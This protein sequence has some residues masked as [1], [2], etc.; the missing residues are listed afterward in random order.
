MRLVGVRDGI[1]AWFAVLVYEAS[2]WT[3]KGSPAASIITSH[4]YPN[5]AP[6]KWG[7]FQFGVKWFIGLSIQSDLL[8]AMVK[9]NFAAV[10]ATMLSR[11]YTLFK[12]P[13]H[14][15]VTNIS[16]KRMSARIVLVKLTPAQDRL[17]IQ[18]NSLEINQ[19][20]L[21]LCIGYNICR[22]PDLKLW[23]E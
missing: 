18:C 17:P 12:D 4:Q 14:G 13:D 2:K 3:S 1:G 21:N 19:A 8:P 6:M 10:D 20:S 15:R 23:L 11:N 5:I 22:L 16:S 7:Q 9:P